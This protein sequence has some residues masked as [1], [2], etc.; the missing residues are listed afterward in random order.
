[1]PKVSFVNEKRD[2][3]VPPGSN[4]RTEAMKAEIPVNHQLGSPKLGKYLNCHGLGTCGSCHV[5]V[6][7][8][9]ENLGPKSFMEKLRLATMMANIG[10]EEQSRLACQVKVNGD[11]SVVTNPGMN[12]HG[13]NFWQKPYPNK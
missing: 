1:M 7:K 4:L 2:I 9:M 13:E 5:I 8:G 11:C 6:Q 12:W 10:S 3:D